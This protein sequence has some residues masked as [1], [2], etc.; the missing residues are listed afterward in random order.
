MSNYTVRIHL[1]SGAEWEIEFPPHKHVDVLKRTIINHDDIKHTLG[2]VYIHNMRLVL[3]PDAGGKEPFEVLSD[4]RTI[5]S[6]QLPSGTILE[7]VI[8]DAPIYSTYDNKIQVIQFIRNEQVDELTRLLNQFNCLELSGYFLGTI[9]SK[10]LAHVLP[11]TH[12]VH[13]NLS[14]CNIGRYGVRWLADIVPLCCAMK[15]LYMDDNQM[16]E[17][18]VNVLSRALPLCHTIQEISLNDNRIGDDGLKALA[19]NIPYSLHVLMLS[20]NGIGNDGAKALAEGLYGSQ[21]TRLDLSRNE[22]G[23]EGVMAISKALP[24]TQLIRVGLSYNFIGDEGVIELSKIVLESHLEYIELSANQI[25]EVGISKLLSVLSFTNN[26]IKLTS[27]GN[28]FSHEY[29]EIMK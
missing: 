1:M 19:Q 15:R 27:G 25:T 29:R 3:M 2:L 9:G 8:S 23:N 20:C 16:D 14:G 26:R 7:L 4:E 12:I 22:I 28:D 17:N 6:Y 13:L 21:I 11:H 24:N 10:M 5:D 18:D